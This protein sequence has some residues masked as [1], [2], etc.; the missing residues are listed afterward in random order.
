[1]VKQWVSAIRMMRKWNSYVVIGIIV[2]LKLWLALSTL[3]KSTLDHFRYTTLEIYMSERYHLS[4]FVWSS[5]DINYLFSWL[6]SFKRAM[7]F[8]CP[9]VFNITTLI[10][11]VHL[12]LMHRHISIHLLILCSKSWFILHN[13]FILPKEGCNFDNNTIERL[14]H[15]EY[16]KN[17]MFYDWKLGYKTVIDPEKWI[18]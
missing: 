18:S 4:H 13:W 3:Y 5:Y 11:L 14:N 10:I 12:H 17:Y 9:D 1:M 16:I 6:L 15:F 2:T 7:I 8:I